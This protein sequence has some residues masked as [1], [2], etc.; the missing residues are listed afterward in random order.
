M[1]GH[2]SRLLMRDLASEREQIVFG[3]PEESHPQIVRA[4]VRHERWFLLELNAA[5]L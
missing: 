2:R 4:H 1:H 3:I 5:R